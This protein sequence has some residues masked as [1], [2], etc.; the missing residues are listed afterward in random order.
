MPFSPPPCAG[1]PQPGLGQLGP[2]SHVPERSWERHWLEGRQGEGWKGLCQRRELKP[3]GD[4]A[5]RKKRGG[6]EILLSQELGQGGPH[7]TEL[8]VW[9]QGL[10]GEDTKCTGLARGQVLRWMSEDVKEYLGH[11]CPQG[12]QPERKAT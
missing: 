11:M 8:V 12:G 9:V 2:S 7:L 6:K 10:E 3:G 1:L 4:K 5:A